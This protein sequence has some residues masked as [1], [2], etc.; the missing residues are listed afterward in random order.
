M[1]AD[2]DVTRA[3]AA[4]FCEVART[5]LL[6]VRPTRILHLQSDQRLNVASTV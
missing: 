3:D 2:Q 4:A 1:S 5:S 6:E